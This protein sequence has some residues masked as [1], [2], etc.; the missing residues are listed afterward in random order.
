MLRKV[1]YLQTDSGYIA[2]VGKYEVCV[3]IKMLDKNKY[4]VVFKGRVIT[5]SV[6][7]Q[8]AKIKAE[9]ILKPFREEEVKK[10]TT[11]R[12]SKDNKTFF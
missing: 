4:E 1:N 7:L 5:S 3:D 11:K 6:G 12:K 8:Q 9:E 2:Y 10:T